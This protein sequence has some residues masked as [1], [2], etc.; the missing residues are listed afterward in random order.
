MAWK[1]RERWIPRLICRYSLQKQNSE[2]FF[3]SEFLYKI[4]FLTF[5]LCLSQEKQMIL[6]SNLSH[7][8]LLLLAFKT[9]A[10]VPMPRDIY[11]P[12]DQSALTLSLILLSRQFDNCI[13]KLPCRL[14]Y[15]HK[16]HSFWCSFAFKWV[17]TRFTDNLTP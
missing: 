5:V 14:P 7:P 8:T 1:L 15:L 16:R 6:S 12:H 3:F 9:L 11:I 2:F 17:K 13:P 10:F 4:T